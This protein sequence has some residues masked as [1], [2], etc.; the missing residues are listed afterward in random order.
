MTDALEDYEGNVSIAGRTITNLRFADD[1][2]GLAGEEKELAKLIEHLNKA[3][4]AYSMKISAEKT[5]LMTSNTSGD[6]QNTSSAI[7]ML[8]QLKRETLC[9][10]KSLQLTQFLFRN[11]KLSTTLPACPRA[12]LYSSLHQNIKTCSCISPVPLSYL[13]KRV[14]G[15][16]A[17]RPRIS[18]MAMVQLPGVTG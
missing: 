5:K 17:H 18:S 11:N 1:I 13:S 12:I 4:T 16:L 3:S 2:G 15:W 7:T 10:V 9:T 8:N 6:D 14:H